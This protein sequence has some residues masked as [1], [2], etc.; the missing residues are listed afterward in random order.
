MLVPDIRKASPKAADRAVAA[1]ERMARR[2]TQRYLHEEFA[3]DDRRELDDAALEIL[4]IEDAEERAALMDRLYRD[5]TDMQRSIRD[6]EVIAQRDR[7]RSARRGAPN[8]QDIA[9]EIWD[10][11]DLDLLQFPEDFVRRRNEGEMFD[12]PS[13]GVEV[14]VAMIEAGG[15]LRA[16]TVRVGGQDGDVLD[17]GSVARARFLEALSLCHR[18]GQVRLPDDD[19]CEEAFSSFSRYRSE[20]L[21]RCSELVRQRTTDQRRQRTIIAALM[22]KALQWRRP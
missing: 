8:P 12:L 16:G 14:G 3:L 20:L 13:G 4:G 1:C 19:V 6:R 17:V 18:A 11:R 15:M 9:D 7:R 21:D 5:V 22:R 10:Q 2:N